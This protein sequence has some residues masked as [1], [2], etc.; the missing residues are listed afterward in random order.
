M[1]KKEPENAGLEIPVATL[2]SEQLDKLETLAESIKKTR[3]KMEKH[4]TDLNKKVEAYRKKQHA[5]TTE[6]ENEIIE[7]QSG[8]ENVIKSS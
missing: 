1:A 4:K 2:S 3:K 5:K 6:F 8:L 7:L